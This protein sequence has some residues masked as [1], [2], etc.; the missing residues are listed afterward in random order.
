MIWG[1][2]PLLHI[3]LFIDHYTISI[4]NNIKKIKKNLSKVL[5]TIKILWKMEHLLRMSKCSIFHN[6]FKYMIFQRRPEALLMSKG[7]NEF[8]RYYYL[9]EYLVLLQQSSLQQ[10]VKCNDREAITSRK[11]N[12]G[13][14]QI[15]LSVRISRQQSQ[16][17]M[18]S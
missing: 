12:D 8:L 13:V 14:F 18:T 3:M 4:F 15:T 9:S 2:N 17:I 6:I 7:S 11:R 10:Q 16:I 5:N 1:F